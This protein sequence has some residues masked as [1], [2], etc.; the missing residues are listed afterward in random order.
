MKHPGGPGCASPFQ[1]K[2]AAKS[3]RAAPQVLRQ[4]ARMELQDL[5]PAERLALVALSRAVARA[6]GVISD[7][8]G[9]VVAELVMAMGEDVYRAALAHVSRRLDDATALKAFLEGVVRPEARQ[10]I[11]ETILELAVTDGL[12]P[13]EVPILKWLDAAWQLTPTL[14]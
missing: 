3:L 4:N 6:D 2:E 1:A 14:D 9:E 8:E 7:K 11:F 12:H 5:Y 10:L 13:Q